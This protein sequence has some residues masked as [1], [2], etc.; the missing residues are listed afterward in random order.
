MTEQQYNQI[1]NQ[2]MPWTAKLQDIDVEELKD[3]IEVGGAG[4]KE[5]KISEPTKESTIL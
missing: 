1:L 4:Y 3:S 5:I 2:A